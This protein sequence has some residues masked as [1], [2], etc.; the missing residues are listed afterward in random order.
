M[1]GQIVYRISPV[2]T[3]EA[4]NALFA[5]S[6]PEY[7]ARDFEPVH[8]RSLA[9]ICAYDNERLI[10]YVNLA[11]DGGIHAFLLDTTVH[12]DRQREGIGVELVRQAVMEASARGI[13]WCMWITSHICAGFTNAVGFRIRRRA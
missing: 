8:S 13:E 11:W 1:S 9:Y 6:W 12:P 3:N 7:K 5:V 4:L 10:G 2:V